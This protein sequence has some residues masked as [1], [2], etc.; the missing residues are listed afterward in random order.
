MEVRRTKLY[1]WHV[2]NNAKTVT[3]AGWEMPLTY[4]NGA[5]EEHRITRRSVGIFD[6]D[7]MGQFEMS[8]P[9]S[10]EALKRLLSFDPTSLAPYESHYALLLDEDAGVIDDL[11]VYRLPDRWL[12][13]V[14]AANREEDFIWMER[15]LGTSKATLVDRSDQLYMVAVQGPRALELFESVMAVEGVPSLWTPPARFFAQE[16]SLAGTRLI[17]GRTG[18]T[19]EDGVEIFFAEEQAETIWNLLLSTA[20]RDRIEITPAGLAARDSLRFE[21]GF[22]LYGHELSRKVTPVEARLTWSCTMDGQFIGSD[23]LRAR[24]ADGGAQRLV[25]LVMDEKAVPREGYL[26]YD[27]EGNEV[28]KVVTGMYAPTADAYAGNA[29]VARNRMK[30]GTELFVEIRGK[31]KRAHV[32]QRPLYRPAYKEQNGGEPLLPDVPSFEERHL[33][34]DEAERK[35]MLSVI[36]YESLEALADAAV[37]EAIR[38]DT[39][40]DL[41]A[42]IS[43]EEAMA[44]NAAYAAENSG[45][46]SLIGMG[47]YGTK[48]PE[49]IKRNILENPSWY[50]QYTPYQAEIAQG[51][52]EALLNFQSMV[53]ELTGMEVSNSSLLD[54]GTAAAEAMLLALRAQPRRSE[55][56]TIVVSSTCHPQTIEVMRT[57][58][59]PQGIRLV[60]GVR[61]D[62]PIDERTFAVMVQYPA[63][64]GTV[65]EWDEVAERTHAAK[66]MFI[67]AADLLSLTLLREPSTFGADAVVGSTQRF[68][69]PMGYGGPHAAFLATFEKHLRLLPGRLV[70]VSKDRH[71]DPGLR[72]ALQTR[73]QH[74]RRDRATS[75]I[76]TAQVLPAIAA[77]MYA[78]YHGPT[79]VTNVAKR[80]RRLTGALRLGFQQL[81]LEVAPKD[82]WFDTLTVTLTNEK[83]SLRVEEALRKERIFLRDYRDGRLGVSVD[84]TT[85]P[86]LLDRVLTV[87]GRIRKQSAAPIAE[88]LRELPEDAGTPEELRRSSPFLTE[89][90]FNS[91]HTET[92]MLRYMKRLEQRDLSLAHSMIPL[93]SC[94]MKLNAS[95][96]MVSL[97]LPGFA[98]LH[99]FLPA[100]SAK[101]YHS[102]FRTLERQLAIV[103]GFAGTTLQ[104]NSGAQGEYTGLMLIR[105]YHESRNEGDRKVC[106]IPDSAHGTNPASAVMAGMEVV[107]LESREDGSIDMEHLQ[108]VVDERRAE[109]GAIMITYPSTHGVFEPEVREVCNV[110]HQAG[111]LVYMDGANL[112]AQVGLT[113]P[114]KI[115]AD[116]CHINLHKTF[117]IP[118]GGGG[119]GMGPVCV[120]PHLVPFLPTHPVVDPRCAH[121]QQEGGCVD[122]VEEPIGPV[123]SA[124]WGSPSVLGISASYIRMMGGEG[125]R[126]ASMVAILNA[127]YIAARLQDAYPVLFRGEHGA[128]AHECIID[129]RPLERETGIGAEDVAKRL[130]DYG[131]HAPTM[132]FPVPG[133]LMIE[134]TESESKEELDRFCDAMLQIRREIDL[135]GSGEYP[136]EDNPLVNAPHTLKDFVTDDWAHPYS[137]ES[138]AYPLPWVREHK[139]W[140]E[141]ARV[142]NVW[143]DRNPQCSC[144]PIAAY[145]GS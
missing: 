145:Q 44:E 41:P 66:A 3:F 10:G 16:V 83:E 138:A 126:R 60:Q 108:R 127:N 47:Y 118:H 30:V 61:E 135:V 25:T 75:N 124:P 50:T 132:S 43:E 78:V 71:G 8:G 24:K 86:E 21:P 53:S 110:I 130:M 17:L 143:G 81:G 58:A 94:T 102:L 93:G 112:N 89:P 98:S 2:R 46:T 141:V 142:D 69:V 133:T 136:A 68:G 105:A 76:C 15:H 49:V 31:R 67:V 106:L 107:V 37:P 129:I 117:A 90:V 28:G 92:K 48:T 137:A 52:L 123:S 1:D 33:G 99:P 103:T 100:E 32:A 96:E 5:I 79:G 57:R 82:A 51:R 36:G 72:L 40:G 73:E 84:E 14:N 131:F 55:R 34:P 80:V 18:Y 39:T 109:L 113:A 22:A 64:D 74:I 29:F 116:C 70:G 13:V 9:D 11:F 85:T 91:H 134:P 144:A 7:H 140:P 20:K 115:G 120:A 128:V 35:E 56:D 38:I 54:E 59:E 101:G 42:P 87:F 114:A 95:A 19:G 4:Q 125:L 45:G 122:P 62:L 119:P 97:T 65:I 121:P 12:I 63:T 77:S 111:G 23:A 6:I 27:A 139:F 104:P 26:V 88:L